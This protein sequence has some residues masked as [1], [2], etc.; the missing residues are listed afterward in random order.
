MK[1]L[2]TI[3]CGEIYLREFILEDAENIYT[4]ANETEIS[5][6]L[7]GWKT[8][9]EQ[10]LEWV[11]EYKIPWN[12]E[13][14]EAASGKLDVQETPLN[15]GVVLKETKIHKAT[16]SQ[17]PPRGILLWTMLTTPSRQSGSGL[18]IKTH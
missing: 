13:F 14:L 11:R 9:R 15:L 6:Y 17:S 16:T 7:P 3:D 12:R 8:T 18:R 10:R 1:N 4:L 2:F 5:K